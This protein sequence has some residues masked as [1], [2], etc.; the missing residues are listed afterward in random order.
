[1]GVPKKGFEEEVTSVEGEVFQDRTLKVNIESQ[2][3][4]P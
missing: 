4:E 1:M 3:K 2:A